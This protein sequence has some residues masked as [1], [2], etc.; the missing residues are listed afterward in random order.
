MRLLFYLS[1]RGRERFL[2]EAGMKK[3]GWRMVRSRFP[4]VC[5]VTR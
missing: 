5:R 3:T 4:G 2:R 1:W